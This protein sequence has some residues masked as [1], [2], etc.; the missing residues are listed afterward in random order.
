MS[1]NIADENDSCLQR[2][3]EGHHSTRHL[4]ICIMLS[5]RREWSQSRLP[6]AGR[7]FVIRT[8]GVSLKTGLILF[9]ADP[10]HSQMTN[11]F[12]CYVIHSGRHE[13][14]RYKSIVGNAWSHRAFRGLFQ[15]WPG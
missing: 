13:P 12:P 2:R 9:F 11:D 6:G 7:V 14:S 8:I 1:L 10:D 15:L 5:G 3:R 4:S